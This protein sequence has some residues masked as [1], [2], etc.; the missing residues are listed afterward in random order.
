MTDVQIRLTDAQALWLLVSQETYRIE[1]NPDFF[2]MPYRASIRRI[3]EQLEQ[4]TP[5]DAISR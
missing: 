4:F 1:Q 2:S 5:E 3:Q